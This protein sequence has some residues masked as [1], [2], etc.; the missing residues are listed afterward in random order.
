MQRTAAMGAPFDPMGCRK[1]KVDTMKQLK[2]A[3]S[4]NKLW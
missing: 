1:V 3:D 4:L 2:K